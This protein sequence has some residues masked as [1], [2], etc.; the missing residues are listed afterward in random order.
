MIKA[1]LF[2]IDGVL[3]DSFNANLAFYRALFRKLGYKPLSEKD[4]I[5]V[6]HFTLE[7]VIREYTR[8]SDKEVQR[9]LAIGK[10]SI[11]ELYP[12]ELLKATSDLG[13]VIKKLH[14]IY[15]LGIV[16]SRL[17]SHIFSIPALTPLEKYFSVS[18][19]FE[20]TKAHKPNPEPLQIAAQKLDLEPE[21]VVYIGDAES[22]VIAAK[23]A[24]M[25]IILYG[26]EKFTDVDGF[27]S[28]F[29]ALPKLI[30]NL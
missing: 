9:M 26:K 17:N 10:E 29:K 28:Q 6:M 25:K 15:L 3:I 13:K 12:Y 16:T 4:F 30:A 22:D 1:V 7:G 14:P 8:E 2:D 5:K 11:E 24:G 21:E 18:V 19:G 20:D 23:A 27:T